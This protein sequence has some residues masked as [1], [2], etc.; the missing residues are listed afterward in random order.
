VVYRAHSAALRG[1]LSEALELADQSELAAGRLRITILLSGS[2]LARGCAWVGVGR[3]SEAYAELRGLLVDGQAGSHVRQLCPALMFLAEAAAHVDQRADAGAV[4][5]SWA[6]R[7][8]TSPAPDLAVHLRYARAVLAD[9]AAAEGLYEEALRQDLHE[10]PFV[11]AML[12]AAYGA[13]L[14]RQR[15][16]VESRRHTR[17]ALLAFDAIGAR[18]WA[19]RARSELAAAGER[20]ET[21]GDP[22]NTVLSP[23]QLEIARLAA[24]GLSNREIGEQLFL[25]PRTIGSHLYRI[26]PKL[27]VTSRVQLAR[28][29]GRET[30]RTSHP[31]ERSPR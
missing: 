20:H 7:V 23:Q 18:G 9:D 21:E 6:L 28:R 17:A 13:W 14:R 30:A 1:H 8:D 4:I 22:L 12:R 31:A 3:F 16:I 25:S 26:F 27:G 5:E 15:R 10:W 24:R 19:A 29:L 2:R 11:Q